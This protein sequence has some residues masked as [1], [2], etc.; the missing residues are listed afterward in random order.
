MVLGP[1]AGVA[2]LV[3]W[4]MRRE[5][6]SFND[7]H[8]R[9]VLNMSITGVIL[10]FIGALTGFAM[11]LWLIWAVIALISIIRGA[12]AASNGEYF[13]YPMTIRFL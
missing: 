3:L 12:M 9:E 1:F 5:E 11:V 4:L 13:R 10:F 7:D 2:P 6:S 8:G